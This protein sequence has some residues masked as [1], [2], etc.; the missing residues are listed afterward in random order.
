MTRLVT[1]LATAAA[2][3]PLLAACGLFGGAD[4]GRVRL[5]FFQ[6]KPE[7][8]ET[9]DRIIA[10]FERDHP[11]VDVRQ[12]HVPD[13]ET[14]IRTRMVREDVPDVMTLNGNATF[15][16]LATAG[17][18]Y[19]FAGSPAVR[20]VSPAILK[21]MNGLGT[22]AEGEVNGVPLAS[23]ADG[24][25]YNKDLFAEHGVEVPGTWSELIAAAEKLR[26]AGVPPFY[27]TFKDAWTAANLFNLVA[28]TL[29][30]ADFFDRLRADDAS[31]TDA[32]GEVADKILRL[33][34]LGQRDRF[35][36]DYNAGNQAFAKG[37]VAMY[38]QGSW[39]IP[40]VRSVEPD[41]ELGMFPLPVAD[42]G[43][44][45][46]VSGVD[47]AVTMAREPRHE[48]EALAF[49][50]YLMRPDVVAA[51]AKEQSA[52][53]PLEGADPTDPAL[54][55]VAPLFDA[56]R[57]VGFADHQIP[58]SVPLKEVTQ[59]FLIDGD[60]AAYLDTLDNEWDKVML[61]RAR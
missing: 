44:T 30:P 51:Y 12:N 16:E 35:A 53:P 14:A 7:A 13:A 5:E 49:V 23:N 31:F 54:A 36:R 11:G 59:Q 47:V 15:G 42:G 22:A 50:E 10:G 46:L 55:D 58:T 6:F 61:R 29:P 28:S 39:A 48:K 3:L 27:F 41:F 40:S 8:I 26:A 1:R 9:F 38:P 4:D 52:V 43:D 57:L 34:R 45:T 25:L 20:D 56:G 24:V 37:E 18:F 33:S 17:V 32:Y 2:A 60:R 19:D 21:I